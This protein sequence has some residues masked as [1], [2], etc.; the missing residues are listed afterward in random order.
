MP[1]FSI[2]AKSDIADIST[3]SYE[4]VINTSNQLVVFFGNGVSHSRFAMDE[5]FDSGDLGYGYI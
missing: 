1:L 3:R 5:V 4:L 2:I